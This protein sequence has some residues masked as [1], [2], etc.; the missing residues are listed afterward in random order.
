M[1]EE[2]GSKMRETLSA[3]VDGEASQLEFHRAM[4]EAG[5]N[6]A[7]N[8]TW[9]RYHLAASVMRKELSPDFIDSAAELRESISR[10]LI[11]ESVPQR[12]SRWVQ[13][14]G[15]IAIAAS[16]AVVAIWGAQHYVPSSPVP[17]VA[18]DKT[19]GQFQEEAGEIEP[20]G[21]QFQLPS[22]FE[23]PQAT[24]RTVSAGSYKN[25][26]V[27]A[28]SARVETPSRARQI[29]MDRQIQAYMQSLVSQ[30]EKHNYPQS[31]PIFLPVEHRPL[32]T[33]EP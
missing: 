4:R 32:H 19:Q 13:P 25:D 26:S 27:Y 16:V 3:L 24:A 7:F 23:V 8:E 10:A 18:E 9:A 20:A 29:E 14:L 5:E 1:N 28:R 6:E 22:G 17:L 30:R 31:N 11:D 12:A 21:P 2:V 33:L 15:R